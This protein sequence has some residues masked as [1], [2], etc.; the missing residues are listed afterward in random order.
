MRVRG[1]FD[2]DNFSHLSRSERV[3]S[4]GATLIGDA[5]AVVGQA[6]VLDV[7]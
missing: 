2:G 5:E 3:L 7:L 6:V 4:G 1:W